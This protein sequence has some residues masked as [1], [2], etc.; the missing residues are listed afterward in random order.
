MKFTH[1]AF[2]LI[3]STLLIACGGSSD[4]DN[5]EKLVINSPNPETIYSGSTNPALL[6]TE[7]AEEFA[8]VLFGS[9][10]SDEN[11]L[12]KR[13]QQSSAKLRNKLSVIDDTISLV[14]PI[15]NQITPNLQQKIITESINCNFSGTAQ[16]QS[17][18]GK[19]I[20]TFDNC[21]QSAGTI[22]NGIISQDI[23]STSSPESYTIGYDDFSV[24]QDTET[25]R[26][27]GTVKL[28]DTTGYGTTN[29]RTRTTRINVLSLHEPSGSETFLEDY[30]IE[31]TINRYRLDVIKEFSSINGKTYI[32]SQGYITT[33]T[34]DDFQFYL[35][36]TEDT[37]Y[38]PDSGTL[39]MTGA[40]QSKARIPEPSWLLDSNFRYRLDLDE[41]GDDGYEFISI[42]DTT[43]LESES[44]TLNEPPTVEIRSK[45][46]TSVT[47]GY[48]LVTETRYI[49][50]ETLYLYAAASDNDNSTFN[51]TW[52]VEEQPESSLATIN[53]LQDDVREATFKPDVKGSYKLSVKVSDPLGSRENIVT[54]MELEIP[55]YTPSSNISVGNGYPR[56]SDRIYQVSFGEELL[57]D[58]SARDI[59]TPETENLADGVEITYQWI[60]RPVDS[61]ANLTVGH[62][63]YK[64]EDYE[65]SS[66]DGWS[67]LAWHSFI[68]DKLGKYTL[69]IT[70]TDLEGASDTSTVDFKVVTE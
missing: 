62:E 10:F 16:Q 43:T 69:S 55:N 67:Y 70:A 61:E 40:S 56:G 7:N 11:F 66:T 57:F 15:T 19:L 13:S 6:T 64:H 8:S 22:L 58:Y 23:Q 45:L 41:N 68:P 34:S 52:S 33:S 35:S 65:H 39:Y 63:I 48:P 30:V 27:I 47:S 14:T 24:T 25:F 44:F 37:N 26:L 46:Y 17:D 18:T 50:G 42:Q 2:L 60:Q 20:Y 38:I 53:I 5:E 1:T 9:S 29:T 28:F 49:F 3:V 21:Q 4:N 59:D 31:T 51:Y 12:N 32:G 36:N 54:F